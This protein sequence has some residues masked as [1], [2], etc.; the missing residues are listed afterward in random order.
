M[1]DC[2][3]KNNEVETFQSNVTTDYSSNCACSQVKHDTAHHWVETNHKLLYLWHAVQ[4]RIACQILMTDIKELFRNT[5]LFGAK[6]S[7]N[8]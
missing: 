5:S 2:S 6:F 3:K 7:D 4:H 1:P 8:L